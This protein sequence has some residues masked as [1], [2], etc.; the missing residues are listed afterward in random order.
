MKASGGEPVKTSSAPAFSSVGGKQSA[1]AITSRW[2]CIVP[3]GWPVVPEVKA[4]RQTS[5]D[6]VSTAAKGADFAAIASSSPPGPPL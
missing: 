1:I 3:L 6:A 5:S 4:M 2:K